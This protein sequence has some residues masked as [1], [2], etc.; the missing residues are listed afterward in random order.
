VICFISYSDTSLPSG[1]ETAGQAKTRSVGISYTIDTVADGPVAF[2]SQHFKKDRDAFKGEKT[3]PNG[4][5]EEAF[6]G[7]EKTG[8]DVRLHT[9]FRISNLT[10]DVT[11]GGKNFTGEPDPQ[12][13]G[14]S[15]EHVSDLKSG[16]ESVA[17]AL[18]DNVDTVMSTK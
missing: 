17:R 18:A 12:T 13:V 6:T 11:V 16:A 10:V 7:I 2:A 8:D 3:T 14:D 5:G 15:P 9:G 1:N 4:I